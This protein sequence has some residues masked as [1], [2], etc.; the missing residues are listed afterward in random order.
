[1]HQNN[2][3]PHPAAA[4][5]YRALFEEHGR[6]IRALGWPDQR[7]CDLR[8]KALTMDLCGGMEVLDYGCGL[9]HLYQYLSRNRMQPRKYIG[10]DMLPEFID[11]NLNYFDLPRDCGAEFTSI[12]GADDLGPD[13][14]EHIIAC[15]VFSYRGQLAPNIHEKHVEANLAVLFEKCTEALHVDFL[16][17]DPDWQGHGLYY[18]STHTLINWIK[19]MGCRRWSIDRGYLPYE[20]CAHFY[21]RAEI[22]PATRTYRT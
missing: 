7:R 12:S 13:T 17:P 22:D 15:G 21:K 8:Y 3:A 1:M 10:V 16:I 9:G 2:L 19:A 11:S 14:Y 6:D 4:A 5:Q 18:Q 20:Y